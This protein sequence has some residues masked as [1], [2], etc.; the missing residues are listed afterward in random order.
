MFGVR[1]GSVNR[2]EEPRTFR[3]AS[4]GISTEN[5]LGRSDSEVLSGQATALE[6]DPSVITV[7]GLVVFVEKP[8]LHRHF[9]H[10]PLPAIKNCYDVSISLYRSVAFSLTNIFNEPLSVYPLTYILP[11]NIK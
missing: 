7:V 3:M 4:I 6:T 2:R 10:L 5:E 9:M 1:E 11:G 8:C